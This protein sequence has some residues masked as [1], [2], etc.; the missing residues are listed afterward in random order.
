MKKQF[1]VCVENKNFSGMSHGLIFK[2]GASEIF[3]NEELY[4][5][6]I[7]KGYQDVDVKAELE[8]IQKQKELETQKIEAEIQKRVDERLKEELDKQGK[9]TPDKK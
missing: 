1:K 8:E 9:K 4:H 5:R 6:L 7:S 3:D 2:G